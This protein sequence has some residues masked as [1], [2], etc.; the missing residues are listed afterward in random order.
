[1][2]CIGAL[3][4]GCDNGDVTLM[5]APGSFD[6]SFVPEGGVPPGAGV[7]DPCSDPQQPCRAGLICTAGK[8]APGHA[9]PTGLP[10]VISD[11]CAQGDYCFGGHCELAGKG[12]NGDT[13]KSDA[14]C[15][16]GM[17]CDI[18][19]FTAQCKPEGTNDVGKACSTSGDCYG[20]LICANKV[21]I[22]P[23][24][25][26]LLGLPTWKGENCTDDPPPT[27]A[28]F[29]VP[30]GT[31]DGDFFRLPFPNNV[32]MKN[33][34]PDLTGFPTPGAELLGFDVVDRYARDL[35]KSADGFSTY[36]TVTLRFSGGV[37]FDSLKAQGVV[38]WVDITTTSGGD[39]G[40]GWSATTARNAYVCNNSLSARPLQGAA[41]TPGST[42]ALYITTGATAG[43][44]T[45][46][47]EPDLTALLAGTAPTDAT[48]AAAYAAYAPFR[49]WLTAKS[50]NPATILTAAVFTVGHPTKVPSQLPAAV[51]AATHPSAANWTLC[52]GTNTS[53]CP[54]ATGD[55]ACPATPDPGF[56]E[57]H[58]IVTLPI[59][60]NGTEPYLTPDQGGDLKVDANGIAQMVRTEPVCMALTVPKGA[61][62]PATGWPTVIYAH[63][64]GGS[65]RSHITEGIAGRL[66]KV[67]DGVGFVNVAVLGIDQVE[68]GTRRG[69]STQSP[70]NL[71]YNF[72]NPLAAR[73]NALQGAAD[74]IALAYF[75]KAL[76]LAA[77]ADKLT[78]KAGNLAL[79]GHSQGAT[80][81]G[82]AVGYL[83][84]AAAVP[85]VLVSGEGASLIDALIYKKSPVDVAD[86]LPIAIEDTPP[87]DSSHPVLTLLQNDLDPDDPL[88]HAHSFTAAAA[89]AK[90]VFQVYGLGDTYAPPATEAT[91]ALTALRDPSGGH[92]IAPL[93]P[94][95][96]LDPIGLCGNP[97]QP[98]Y[99]PETSAVSGNV[100][101]GA[102]KVTAVVREYA[103]SGYDGH[104]V[105]QQNPD[106]Q[107]DTAHFLAD[108]TK[109][110][111][112]TPTVPR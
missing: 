95:V 100:T 33:G 20:G 92:F 90:H 72:A 102:V 105:A 43:G 68:H 7:G 70:D 39:I 26:G 66:A 71:F 86:A 93:P 38:R 54:Q 50:V 18:A 48:L 9:T 107:K 52:D 15:Q 87:I 44:K 91:F 37:D 46:T 41:L 53:P 11:E 97:P 99:Q 47:P 42:Y 65:F 10:C 83:P 61:T 112:T 67:D 77:P 81:V 16:A 25:P 110:A 59:F 57:W 29:H 3:W 109:A 60:Q 35:E 63:G 103:P 73:G 13:C 32:R 45:M 8:C 27:K 101:V 96:T 30:R 108:V 76:A 14:D 40:F 75:A 58:A 17:R 6:G 80:E 23:P 24:A 85:G 79:W 88:N 55:R 22:V 98:C 106:G 1:M 5:E 74:Q 21:C 34:H 62:M 4:A 19:G 104:F 51:A 82:I 49:A 89:N 84:G 31:N 69:S 28:Y 56:D 78:F 36:G 94:G 2:S 111:L 64:T 12:G